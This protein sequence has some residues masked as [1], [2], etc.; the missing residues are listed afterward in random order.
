MAATVIIVEFLVIVVNSS[1]KN[2]SKLSRKN[3]IMLE[4]KFF[5]FI[6]IYE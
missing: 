6:K 3:L 4:A 1:S 2:L 5:V